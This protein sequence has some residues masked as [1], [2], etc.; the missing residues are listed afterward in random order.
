MESLAGGY[1]TLRCWQE[2]KVAL[3]G[4]E[5]ARAAS[6]WCSPS[7][8]LDM[9]VFSLAL[10]TL[11]LAALWTGSQSISCEYRH[12]AF[13][14][15][16]PAPSPAPPL[17]GFGGVGEGIRASTPASAMGLGV[18][19]EHRR[20]P[21]HRTIPLLFKR[22]KNS[23]GDGF[24]PGTPAGELGNKPL[25]AGRRGAPTLGQSSTAGDARGD[26]WTEGRR[27]QR[28]PW[29]STRTPQGSTR[30]PRA[31]RGRA[32]TPL[33]PH[34]PLQ[35]AVPTVRAATRRCSSGRK[36]LTFSSGATRRRLPTA[37]AGLCGEYPPPQPSSPAPR[38][39]PSPSHLPCRWLC[40]WG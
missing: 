6:C 20:L 30:S 32:P 13:P 19:E 11:L 12:G 29:G 23:L 33:T 22:S 17:M 39:S 27:E 36:S 34:P 3:G 37:P 10:L 9:K 8:G 31:R 16:V 28:S 18:G 2:K 35:S 24:S 7:P 14:T 38:S 40:L 1:I 4:P 5:T 25:W 15:D 26:P 21:E